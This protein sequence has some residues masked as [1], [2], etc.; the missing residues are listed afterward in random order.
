MVV[1]EAERAPTAFA[2]AAVSG[3][4]HFFGCFGDVTA[5]TIA[6]DAQEEQC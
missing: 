4:N 3:V 6:L 1:F 2:S 5:L